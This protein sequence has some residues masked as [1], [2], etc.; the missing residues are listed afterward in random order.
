MEWP[1]DG[2]LVDAGTLHRIYDTGFDSLFRGPIRCLRLGEMAMNFDE[3]SQATR[4]TGV[5]GFLQTGA[6]CHR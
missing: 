3:E 4:G 5:S 1:L 6:L 2:Q